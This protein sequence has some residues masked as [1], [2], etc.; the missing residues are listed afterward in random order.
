MRKFR[1]LKQLSSFFLIVFLLSYCED[2]I[3]DPHA[4]ETSTFLNGIE[5]EYWMYQIQW[6]DEYEAIDELDNTEYEMLV[7]EPGFNFIDF[8]YDTEYLVSALKYRPGGE[9]RILLAYIDI[10]QAED[11][12]SYWAS[13]W[14]APTK[15]HKGSP[16][17]LITI[18]PDGWSGNYPVAYWDPDW[19]SLWLGPDGLIRQLIE[20]G[21]DGI[22]LDWVEAYDDDK[23]RQEAES[24]GLNPEMEMITFIQEMRTLG[25]GIDPGFL[26]IPQN[27]PYL[28]DEDPELYA[29]II[30]GIATED[31]WYYGEGDADWDSRKAGDLEGGDRH[32]GE[33]STDNRIRQNKKYLSLG[34]P[35]F[36]VDYCR[37]DYNADEVYYKSRQNGFI[38]IVTRVALSQPTETPPF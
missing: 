3:Y 33:Y 21:F 22:Y 26:I 10:G 17:F 34:L 19:K 7:V 27:A 24:M 11:Y 8:A 9:E 4:F 6:L 35:V 5:V 15:D 28:L 2:E 23:V 12:R 25:K 1:L 18:D 36:T 20:Y 29:S 30:D 14:V 13:D 38:P 32:D 16:E 37:D 31:T